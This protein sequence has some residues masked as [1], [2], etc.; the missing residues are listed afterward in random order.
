MRRAGVT[1]K[2]VLFFCVTRKRVL[3]SESEVLP[4]RAEPENVCRGWYRVGPFVGEN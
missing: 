3:S 2:S 4:E 1:F